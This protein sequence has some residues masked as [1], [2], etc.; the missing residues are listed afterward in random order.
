MTQ[1]EIDAIPT[2][3]PTRIIPPRSVRYARQHARIVERNSVAAAGQLVSTLV[4]LRA[5][6]IS[7]EVTEC[8]EVNATYNPNTRTIR[9]C[10]ELMENFEGNLR[11]SH[12]LE[13]D[14]R[15]AMIYVTLHEIGHALQDVLDAN[16]PDP[17][18]NEDLADLFAFLIT[19]N[20]GNPELSWK[21]VHSSTLWLA[22]HDAHQPIVPND[23]DPHRAG[24]ER[25]RIGMCIMYGRMRDKRAADRISDPAA[26]DNL[27]SVAM[28]HWNDVLR[29]YTRLVGGNTFI[30]D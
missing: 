11:D 15:M 16:D 4:N 17:K 27:T 6:S 23:P 10:Y 30:A 28:K 20:T 2:S 24:R 12:D 25:A 8:G 18:T 22:R 9:V 3:F 1:E 19:T 29:P 14:H 7:V 21:A 5:F 13:V 26:C